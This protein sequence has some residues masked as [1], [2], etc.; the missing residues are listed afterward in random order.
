[1]AKDPYGAIQNGQ[2]KGIPKVTLPLGTVVIR[3]HNGALCRFVK[4]RMDGVTG[5]RW[6][7][8]A[9]WWWEKNKGP[10]PPGKIVVHVDGDQLNDDPK[11]FKVGTPGTKLALVHQRDPEWSRWQHRRAARKCA[12]FNRDRGRINRASNFLKNW[13]YPVVDEMGVIL[14]VPFRKR[15]RLLAGFGV[16]VSGYPMNGHG[17]KPSSRVQRA[18]TSCPVRP[19]KSADLSFRRYTTYCL[20]DPLTREF[21]GPISARMDQ[22]VAQLDRMGIWMAAE[23]AARKDL[24]ARK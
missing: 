23:Q 22:V 15:K 24:G 12:A 5:R 16:D 7:H 13:W 20:I 9:R 21:R 4:T 6:T 14:N 11:N 8:Y 17:K 10:V 1:M 2:G 3:K 18:M 19:T